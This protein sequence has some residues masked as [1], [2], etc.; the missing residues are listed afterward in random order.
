MSKTYTLKWCY[1]PVSVFLHDHT[2]EGEHTIPR[3]NW[4]ERTFD[5][6]YT[7]R[8]KRIAKNLNLIYKRWYGTGSHWIEDENGC[9]I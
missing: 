1:H 6:F 3:R 8:C 7:I 5:F 4:F 9:K 2:V